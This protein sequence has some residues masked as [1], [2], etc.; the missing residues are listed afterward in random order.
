MTQPASIP[1]DGYLAVRWVT[2]IAVPG[3]PTAAEINAGS[4]VD[5]SCYLAGGGFQN[6]VDEQA[7]ADPR[8]CSRQD[9]ERPGRFKHNLALMYVFNPTSAPD[10]AAYTAL[11]YLATGFIVARY[12]LPFDTAFAAA[13]KV[14]VYPSQCGWRA[15][16]PV[17]DNSVFKIS[18]KLYIRG[19][20]EEDAV[21]V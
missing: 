15:K 2:S 11:T 7:V 19:E 13:Q 10:N 6:G 21:V 3:S 9:L 16:V 1:A 17:E 14:D 8:L 18:Q 12:G 5:I 4:S 20:V